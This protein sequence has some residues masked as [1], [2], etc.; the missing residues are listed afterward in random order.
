MWRGERLHTGK[1]WRLGARV[2][3]DQRAGDDDDADLQQRSY[4]IQAGPR[5]IATQPV[6]TAK[7]GEICVTD[8]RLQR[9]HARIPPHVTRGRRP[10]AGDE[11]LGATASSCTQRKNENRGNSCRAQEN[12]TGETHTCPG[13]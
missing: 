8:Y 7:P 11:A 4:P 13:H 2:V 10:G 12:R 6:H 9:L 5:I 3:V 1:S